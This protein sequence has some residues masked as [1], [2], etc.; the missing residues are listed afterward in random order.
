[1]DDE[2]TDALNAIIVA[3]RRNMTLEE[4]IADLEFAR[5][6]VLEAIGQAPEH[7]LAPEA[8]GDFAVNG[9]IA[10]P[11]T[12]RRGHGLARKRGDMIEKIHH[13]GIAV[14]SLD[15][16]LKF[17]SETLGLPVHASAT[18][19]EQGVRA[20][21][22]TIGQSEIELLEPLS[23]ESPVGKFLERKGEGLH[24]ICFQTPDVDAEL[25]GLKA[26]GVEL[27]DQQPRKGLVGMICFL[28]PKASR[29]LWSWAPVGR[30]GRGG[31][32]GTGT[33]SSAST[34]S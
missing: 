6:L 1:V 10:R 24:H 15:E 31:R 27:V 30:N 34:M 3:L 23:P 21:L 13:V 7:A 26:K 9:S 19:E 11:G 12:R 2:Q 33:C 4:L 17:Y 29:A 5:S 28:H 16:A 14:H 18:V 22:L 20:A 8:Y 32:V 25:E